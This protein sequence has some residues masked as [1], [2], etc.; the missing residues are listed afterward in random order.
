MWPAVLEERTD[1]D[2]SHH[3]PLP[4]FRVK[5][6]HEGGREVIGL[7]ICE[8]YPMEKDEK[9][10][11]AGTESR[12]PNGRIDSRDSLEPFRTDVAKYVVKKI[13]LIK[14]NTMGSPLDQ[15]V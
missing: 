12:E 9:F 14:T 11:N 1:V 7:K 8:Q 6:I 3:G 10:R 2:C 5:Q 13:V 15:V 4:P